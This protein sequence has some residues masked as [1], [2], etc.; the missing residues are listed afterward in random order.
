MLV[1]RGIEMIVPTDADLVINDFVGNLS[2]YC[3]SVLWYTN[4]QMVNQIWGVTTLIF[5]ILIY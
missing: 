2:F 3:L 4:V 5:L 1:V